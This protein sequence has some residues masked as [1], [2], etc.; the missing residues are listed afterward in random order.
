MKGIVTDISS[1]EYHAIHRNKDGV[2]W[3]SKSSLFK[4][5]ND[6]EEYGANLPFK[7]TDLVKLGSYLDA[8]LLDPSEKKNFYNKENNPHLTTRKD[9]VKVCSSQAAKDWRDAKLESGAHAISS[10][11]QWEVSQN[12]IKIQSD[13]TAMQL[14]ANMK[15]QCAVFSQINN[16]PFKGLIDIVP[17]PNGM[18]GNCLGDLKRTTYF[19]PE[20]FKWHAINMGY[21]WQ[22][23]CYLDIWNTE[24]HRLAVEDPSYEPDIR[25]D[26][27]F[28][29]A[30][31]NAPYGCGV[32]KLHN[33]LIERGR[34]EVAE[35]VKLWEVAMRTGEFKNP[36]Q[37]PVEIV[38]LK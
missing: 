26:W 32:A 24:Q 4:F 30:N 8:L 10:A 11:E 2:K 28:L 13:P 33:D 12:L 18:F 1:S 17:D 37:L 25:T 14:L 15:P 27:V 22:A 23:A 20:K 21:H 34:Q 35:A 38:T 19:S 6:Q 9:G 16:I 31:G 5:W 36:F 3:C 7:M 29:L